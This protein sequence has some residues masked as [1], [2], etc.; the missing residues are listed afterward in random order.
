MWR[1]IVFAADLFSGYRHNP[2]QHC[3]QGDLHH[4]GKCWCDPKENFG[5]C[6]VPVR[7]SFSSNVPST[8]YEWYS[9]LKRYDAMF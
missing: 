6:D 4:K 9:C 1:C 2:F 8:D 3:P 7:P 5:A